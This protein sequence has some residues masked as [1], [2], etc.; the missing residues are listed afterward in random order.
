[1]DFN[2]FV[3][4]IFSIQIISITLILIS[5]KYYNNVYLIHL[6][7]KIPILTGLL[8]STGIILTF[9][10]FSNNYT[11]NINDTTV[12]MTRNGFRDMQK[13][14]SDNY[15][16]CPSFID[17]LN[18]DFVKEKFFDSNTSYRNQ[19]LNNEDNVTINYI[20]NTI[21]NSMTNYLVTAELTESS[22]SRWMATFLSY[23][24][25]QQLQERWGYL[26]Y[27]FGQKTRKLVDFL[28]KARN[29]NKFENAD[30]LIKFCETLIYSK[31]FKDILKF[32]DPTVINIS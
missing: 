30:E 26:K 15:S 16:K 12:D 17:S 5:F 13:M 31:E 6:L 4:V 22:D 11:K 21:F 1:M 27:N 29:E 19:D 28:L 3:V 7:P 25:S 8:T 10:L 32:K 9:M 18:F 14:L 23:L 24:S 20:S 2:R